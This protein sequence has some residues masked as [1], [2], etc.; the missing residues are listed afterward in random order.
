ATGG[1]P[2]AYVQGNGIAGTSQLIV[3]Q[4]R[5]V[6]VGATFTGQGTQE[7]LH[8]ATVAV[9]GQVPLERLVHA[10]PSFP[11]V[12]EGWLRP[13]AAFGLRAR[14]GAQDSGGV[15][16][17]M[18]LPRGIAHRRWRRSDYVGTHRPPRR[19]RRRAR[20]RPGRLRPGPGDGGP[21]G[22]RPADR[23]PPPGP[24]THP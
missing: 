13:L 20:R 4:G 2:G 18:W 1:V 8:S 11:T 9:A 7:L 12:R 24:R 5:R 17:G 14:G 3:D 21:L 16:G 19:R 15:P 6:V 22:P 23:R 10:V